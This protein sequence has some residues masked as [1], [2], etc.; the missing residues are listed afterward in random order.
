MRKLRI[1]VDH[2]LCMGNAQC[3]GLAPGVFQHNENRQSE[4]IDPAGASE[5]LIVKAASYCPTGAIEV[6]DAETGER[7]FPG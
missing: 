2:D 1:R 6:A 3:V 5:E 4:V 7:I